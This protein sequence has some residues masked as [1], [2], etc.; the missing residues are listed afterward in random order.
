MS[1]AESDQSG[2]SQEM[3]LDKARKSSETAEISRDE[4]DPQLLSDT[5]KLST[6][7]E[8]FSCLSTE[9]AG[10]LTRLSE[11]AR[12][13]A[14]QL[15]QICSE[16]DL[17]KKEL[18][19]IYGIEAS[20]EALERLAQDHRQRKESFERLIS[21][22]RTL[23]EAEKA[24]RVNGEKEY[25]EKLRMRRQN[26]EEEYRQKWAGEKLRLQRQLEEELK[27]IQEEGL[28]RPGIGKGMS[29]PGADT[30]AEG[31]GMGSACPGTR[32][33]HGEAHYTGSSSNFRLF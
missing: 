24:K 25:Q 31:D 18:K 1:G 2:I 16:V 4:M 20:A 26:E 3:T 23:W 7:I 29:G 15:S 6:E 8:R 30:Q 5:N 27:S 32:S 17:K 21:D 33:I 12:K 11:G 14:E 22:Q 19:A 13:S 9:M 28:R 10:F